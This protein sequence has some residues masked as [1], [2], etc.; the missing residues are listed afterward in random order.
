MI[1]RKLCPAELRESL[2]LRFEAALDRS[3]ECWIWTGGT[4]EVRGK[5]YG[6][7]T[8]VVADG[9]PAWVYAHRLA[10]RLY[11]GPVPARMTPQT[12]GQSLCCNP[13]H[14]QTAFQG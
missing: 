3:G 13:A 6:R 4:V 7:L 5:L 10:Y 14:L 9:R 2:I 11:I 8:T 1:Q 12:C